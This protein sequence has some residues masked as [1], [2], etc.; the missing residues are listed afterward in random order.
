MKLYPVDAGFLKC[1]GGALFGVVPKVMWSKK[2]PVDEHNLCTATMRCL[3]ID[4]DSHRILIDA[5]A[6]DK[7]D[8]KYIKNNGLH[9]D[10]TLLGS[11]KE[12]GYKADDIT[13]VIFSHM[14]WDHC[15]GS[16]AT[17]E[18]GKTPELVFKNA[19][20]WV[21]TQQW[22]QA[23][24]PNMRDGSAYFEVDRATL[25][26]SGKVGFIEREGELFPGVEVRIFNGHTPGQIIPIIHYSGRKVVFTADLITVA[27][28]IPIPWVAAYDLDPVIAM[29][30]KQQ[31][32][33]EVVSE[34][35]VLFFEHDKYTECVE[36]EA[37]VKWPVVKE[38]FMLAELSKQIKK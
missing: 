32:L 10:A 12:L 15:G 38:R 17:G 6:G 5:G 1:D 29:E 23:W 22:E 36:L 3:L 34:N 7:Y 9:G 8:E 25:R 19:T 13:D 37:D 24:N 14:H 20:H 18:D 2:Y 30:E 28:S 27:A 21:T 4:I 11:L 26:D 33:D 16:V 31:F 35:M